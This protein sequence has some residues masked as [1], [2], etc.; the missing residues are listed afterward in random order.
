[1]LSRLALVA[2]MTVAMAVPVELRASGL[3]QSEATELVTRFGRAWVTTANRVELLVDGPESFERRLELVRHAR[4]H[5]FMSTYLWKLDGAGQQFLAAVAETVRRRRLEDPGFKAL[6]LFDAVSSGVAHDPLRRLYRELEAAGA[7]VRIF[8]PLTW[9]IAPP[10]DGRLHEKL[11]VVDGRTAILGSRN[12]ADEYFDR[13]RPWHNIEVLIEGDAAQEAQMHFLKAWE[14]VARRKSWKDFPLP[15]ETIRLQARHF[16]E[17][18][19][20]PDEQV[21]AGALEPYMNRDFFPIL[22]AAPSRTPVGVLYDSSLIYDAAPTMELAARLIDRATDEIVV[23]SPYPTFTNE[24]VDRL[25]VARERGIRVRVIVNSR[26]ALNYGRRVWLASVP[27]LARL[28]DSGAEIYAWQGSD[29]VRS[30]EAEQQC[31]V[32]GHPGTMLHSKVLLVDDVAGMV[33][34]SNFNYRSAH[35]NTELGAVILDPAFNR[36]LRRSVTRLLADEGTRVACAS[37]S[38]VRYV[39]LPPPAERLGED[40][41]EDMRRELGDQRGQLEGWSFLQ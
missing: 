16:W 8:N 36:R 33:H 7:E 25:L 40:A 24:I 35:Y 4:H 15:P 20:F 9:G 10:Y 26:D 34:S 18:G 6:F 13:D 38:G 1:M 22:P 5:I 11:L 32:T 41:I 2:G 31:Q 29:V 28:A 3:T 12:I 27:P 14:L 19:R 23:V 39:T 30:L 17:T 21:G 37:T